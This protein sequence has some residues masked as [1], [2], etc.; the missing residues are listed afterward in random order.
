MESRFSLLAGQLSGDSTNPG[1]SGPVNDAP[2]LDAY[3][4]AVTQAVDRVSP[5]VVK[6]DVKTASSR[7]GGSGSGFVFTPDGLVLTNSHVVR[8]ASSIQ[9]SFH[10]GQR[11]SAT[12]IGEDADT[13]TAVLRTDAKIIQPAVLG[14]SRNLRVGQLAIAVG[15]PFGF[16]FTVTAGVVSALGRS[17][18]STT[19][20]MMEEVIQTDAALNPGNSGGPLVNS[21]GEV[22]GINTATIVSAQG[23][24]FAIGIDTAKVVA[25]Q[26]LQ[27]GRVRRSW[28]GISG[29]NVPLPR[30]LAYEYQLKATTGIL[31]VSVQD[32]GPSSRAELREGD[33]IT[34]LAGQPVAGIDELHRLLKAESAGQRLTIEI[35]RGVQRLQLDIIPEPKPE[36]A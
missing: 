1:E 15:N 25:S 33:I 30:R 10:D 19:G 18:R 13:D 36:E 6:I 7:R 12:L 11:A 31:V 17:M 22:V 28:I 9:L 29:Q 24:C 23:L 21:R 14:N 16:Q 35:L 8:G 20:R 4:T 5:S 26:L 32:D 27:Y 3:S 34:G 2:L